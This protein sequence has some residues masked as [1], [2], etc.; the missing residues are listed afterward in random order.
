MKQINCG[1]HIVSACRAIDLALQSVKALF[2]GKE[3]YGIPSFY[4]E[5]EK[6]LLE[7]RFDSATLTCV[8]NENNI[9]EKVFLFLDD[10]TD[11]THYIEYCNE[12]YHY[13]TIFAGWI[14]NNRLIQISTD[15][16]E[17]SLRVLPCG[18]LT[19]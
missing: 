14:V 19:T 15:N 1:Q 7:I 16:D 12:R 8:F 11:I 13:E 5:G 9:C 2:Y 17:Y 4:K 18:G 3:L 10:P 6:N